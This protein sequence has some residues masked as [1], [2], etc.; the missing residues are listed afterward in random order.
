MASSGALSSNQSSANTC[1]LL[2][3]AVCPSLTAVAAASSVA[4]S[5]SSTSDC[6]K[7]HFFR[8]CEAFFSPLPG[9]AG[10][11][12]SAS[13]L[14][15]F[16][17]TTLAT[18]TTLGASGSAASGGSAPK[19]KSPSSIENAAE[20]SKTSPKSDVSPFF[21]QPSSGLAKLGPSPESR[22]EPMAPL[23]G[24]AGGLERMSRET[25]PATGAYPSSP[26]PFAFL[27]RFAA[28]FFLPPAP[29]AP[30]LP[31]EPEES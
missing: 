20:F 4:P 1:R 13:S 7:P 24:F 25:S 26:T 23:S 28:P 6:A 17:G 11:T 19:S 18:V 14:F 3:Y 31:G 21:F 29:V 2:L 27:A 9:S 16:L 22:D 15:S 12:A 8:V 5:A 10:S 30:D